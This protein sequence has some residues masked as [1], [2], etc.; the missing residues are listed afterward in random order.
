[1]QEKVYKKRI[2][3]IDE[4]HARILTA[5]DKMDQRI[6]D[7]QSDSGAHI[8]VHALKL[9]VDILNT[10]CVSNVFLLMEQYWLLDICAK[11]YHVESVYSKAIH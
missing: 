2:R 6:I 4:L 3:D 11:F 5:W 1:M 10:H 8:F 9:K 7:K